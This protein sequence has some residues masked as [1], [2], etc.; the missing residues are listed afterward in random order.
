MFAMDNIVTEITF[1]VTLKDLLIGKFALI[2]AIAKQFKTDNVWSNVERILRENQSTELY[3]EFVKNNIQKYF[4]YNV[5]SAY[6]DYEINEDLEADE[7]AVTIP[8]E[9]LMDKI[10]EA[11]LQEKGYLHI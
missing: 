4:I 1:T 3:I 2:P 7:V 8:V 5:D 9:I 6:M 10:D 11:F